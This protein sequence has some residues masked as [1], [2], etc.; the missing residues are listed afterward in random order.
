[1]NLDSIY[2]DY[3]PEYSSYFVRVLR[4]LKSM[5]GMKNSGKLFGGELTEWLI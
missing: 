3:F 1:M 2:A 5:Y 4:L